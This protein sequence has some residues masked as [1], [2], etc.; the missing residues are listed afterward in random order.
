MRSEALRVD[1][2]VDQSGNR[3]GCGIG[4][5]RRQNEMPGEGSVN[6]NMRR[7]GISH[8]TDHDDIGILSQE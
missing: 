5:Q 1:A 2:H 7:L 3:A 8:F 6:T 4:V